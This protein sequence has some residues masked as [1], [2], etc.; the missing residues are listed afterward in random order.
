MLPKV[1]NSGIVSSFFG[2]SMF[3]TIINAL[4]LLTT[5]LFLNSVQAQTT[6]TAPSGF[7]SENDYIKNFIHCD[8]E[9]VECVGQFKFTDYYAFMP[10]SKCLTY[11][12][13]ECTQY[14]QLELEGSDPIEVMNRFLA[15]NNSQ[16]IKQSNNT[17]IITR[18]EKQFYD[19]QGQPAFS[20]TIYYKYINDPDQTEFR[21]GG[22]IIN[23]RKV[24]VCYNYVE[25]LGCPD[26]FAD[27]T[28]MKDSPCEICSKMGN[29][30]DV[31]TGAKYETAVDLDFPLAISR[32]YSSKQRNSGMFGANWRSNYDKNMSIVKNKDNMITNIFFI[33]TIG[34][35]IVFQSS[36]GSTFTAISPDQLQYKL[37][38][39]DNQVKLITP[40]AGIEIY[41]AITQKIISEN[42]LGKTITY[43]YDTNGNLY[44]VVNS[45]GKYLQFTYDSSNSF[46]TA[47]T[48]SNG[49]IIS[50]N[51]YEGNITT[52]KYNNIPQISY[53]YYNGLLTGK[54]DGNGIKYASFTYDSLGRG[55]ENKHLTNDGHEIKKYTFTYDNNGATVTQ[56]NGFSRVYTTTTINNTKKITNM[57]WNGNSEDVQFDNLGNVTQKKTLNGGYENYTYDND[58]RILSY[59]AN[60]KTVNLTY[61]PY[62]NLL[63]QS[64]ENTQNGTRTIYYSY[65]NKNENLGY[66]IIGTN[67]VRANLNIS[68]DSYGRITR[69][70]NEQGLVTT[71][72]YFPIDSSNQ[73]G[74]LKTMNVN[75]GTTIVVNSYDTR[76]NPTNLT[77]NGVTKTMSYDYKGRL[78]TETIN[79]ATNTYTYDL[80]GNMLT[81]NLASGYSLN[82]IYDGAG[83]LLS[84]SDNMGGNVVLTNDDYSGDILKTEVSQNNTLVRARNKIL[85]SLGRTI[86]SWNATTKTK[87]LTNYYTRAN[88]P[89]SITD[90]NGVATNFSWNDLGQNLTYASGRD[91]S[92]TMYDIDGNAQTINANNQAITMNYDDLG[93]IVN[94]SSP[95]TGNRYFTYRKDQDTYTDTKG[96][97]HTLYKDIGGRPGNFVHNNNDS[98]YNYSSFQTYNY[99]TYGN[100]SKI[101]SNNSETVFTRNSLGQLINKT[102]NMLVMNGLKPFPVQYS[103]NSIGQKVTDTYPSGTV[104]T[105][106]YTN[107]FV[108]GIKVGGQTVVSNVNY[109]SLLQEATS[110]IL[111]GRNVVITKDT[112]GLLTNFSETGIFNQDITTDNEG[113]ILSLNDSVSNNNFNVVLNDN[114][115]LLS[116]NINN[117]NLDYNFGD[118]HNLTKQIDGI[119]NYEFTTQ[120]GNNKLESIKYV[121]NNT[122]F[123]Y[124]YDPNGNLKAD[125]KNK[126][127]YDGNN[128]LEYVESKV[129]VNGY[130]DTVTTRYYYNGLNQRIAKQILG[131]QLKYFVYN[132]NNQVIGEYDS[133]G[134]VIAEYV[135]FGLRPVAVKT[136]GSLNIVHTDYLGTPRIITSGTNGGSV[137]WQWKNDNPYGNNKAQGSIEFNLRFAGQY[138]DSESGLH[139]N[140]NRTYNPE[141]GRYLQSDPIGLAGGFNTYN[142]VNKNPLN[143]V[144]PLG[145][146]PVPTPFGT[147]ESSI[148]PDA[149]TAYSS[150]YANREMA[151]SFDTRR[152][153][154]G[155]ATYLNK[156]NR[157]E[158]SI[159]VEGFNESI[160]GK[161]VIGFG[162]SVNSP[163]AQYVDN[164]GVT[165][166]DNG[167]YHVLSGRDF[168][169]LIKHLIPDI[170][171]YTINLLSCNAGNEKYHD[172]KNNGILAQE[173]ANEI[174][175]DSV[176]KANPLFLIV[177]SGTLGT[178]WL[179]DLNVSLGWKPY[180]LNLSTE[181]KGK[182]LLPFEQVI[183]RGK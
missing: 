130:E 166:N 15:I 23:L 155:L 131:G 102:Q 39:V 106:E 143:G 104:V 153:L 30:F 71:Y 43:Q 11:S 177:T 128:N 26:T 182:N 76:G 137:V 56:D 31:R 36:D 109:N 141:T 4:L 121:D 170:N 150:Y 133:N 161:D 136:N 117:K 32:N 139:Y 176:V 116:G 60:G 135:Y 62:S 27:R 49:D 75:T 119:T 74:L 145:L 16:W 157:N 160:N 118:N 66:L 67:D 86:E 95:D 124:E 88:Q 105:Y 87:R 152:N 91:N 123:N 169:K 101:S 8:F 180:S 28:S 44:R 158:I 171:N 122:V 92:S 125:L 94:I 93:R 35:S 17:L 47:V 52:V 42:Y 9:S 159:V 107:G 12:D 21:D 13:T 144:D 85:D 10:V 126:Y 98:Q 111:G 108:T 54:L 173:F 129:I 89:D 70:E 149:R 84:I 99:D 33:N 2:E 103:Y 7:I 148:I 167:D 132:E 6:G 162:I 178:E 174:G 51:Y 138:Y 97:L 115:G 57:N 114:Y 5:I 172:Y 77:V 164:G 65:N 45:L 25:G 80:D 100:V 19:Y 20:F 59:S 72:T 110:W 40:E 69:E 142:Y 140:M 18:V 78:L 113:H 163:Y 112:D 175:K 14:K 63:T 127:K 68:K 73:S 38:I 120:Y 82:M 181:M 146:S 37:S 179:D 22:N 165:T 34:D 53:E 79:G 64:T 156:V 41:D 46:I 81:S 61:N 58:G 168:A 96:T 50:Y 1:T 151:I 3:K 55:I 183:F 154:K 83:R 90:A 147:Y 134:N 29:P 24:P 48:A